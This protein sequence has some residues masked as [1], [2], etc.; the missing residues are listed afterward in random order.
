MGFDSKQR[1]IGCASQALRCR[2]FSGKASLLSKCLISF[3]RFFGCWHRSR[4]SK[5]TFFSNSHDDE[6]AIFGRNFW[7]DGWLWYSI[8]ERGLGYHRRRIENAVSIGKWPSHCVFQ[9]VHHWANPINVLVIKFRFEWMSGRKS[10]SSRSIC[11]W[12]I[13]GL[14]DWFYSKGETRGCWPLGHDFESKNQTRFE[15]E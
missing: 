7:L 2:K 11:H 12:G 14:L 5:D 6:C 3:P 13:E 1:I 10:E 15:L 9:N 4:L 8:F